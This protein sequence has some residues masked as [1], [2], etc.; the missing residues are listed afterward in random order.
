MKS[1][2]IED[3]AIKVYMQNFSIEDGEGLIRHLVREVVDESILKFI[4][5]EDDSSIC[6]NS[7]LIKMLSENNGYQYRDTKVVFDGCDM[8][9]HYTKNVTHKMKDNTM[10]KI[11]YAVSNS[12]NYKFKI[13]I[14]NRCV[15][16]SQM[17]NNDIV[18]IDDNDNDTL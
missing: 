12:D 18:V 8:T 10:L 3:P 2:I 9:I 1:P 15:T 4:E 16:N 6:Y 5:T 11:L 14:N 7:L 13:D 17:N